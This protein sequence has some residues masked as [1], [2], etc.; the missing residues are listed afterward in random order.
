LHYACYY[1]WPLSQLTLFAVYHVVK[2][3]GENTSTQE[4]YQDSAIM[5]L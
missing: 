2:Y 3:L 5:I 4:W 1:I